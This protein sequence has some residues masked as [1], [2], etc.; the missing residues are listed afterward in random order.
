MSGKGYGGYAKGG[1]G[2]AWSSSSWQN[3]KSS[4]GYEEDAWMG[5]GWQ[6]NDWEGGDWKGR[7]SKGSKKGQKGS[8]EYEDPTNFTD[9]AGRIWQR[10][11]FPKAVLRA[12]V[13]KSGSVFLKDDGLSDLQFLGKDN[14]A[15]VVHQGN[16]HI[17]RRPGI[18]WSEAAASAKCAIS[19][20][21]EH[22]EIPF[23][24]LRNLLVKG[25]PAVKDALEQIDKYS[26][27]CSEKGKTEK[28]ADAMK[29]LQSW[30]KENKKE[31]W[32]A[33]DGVTLGA[34]RAYV[35]GGS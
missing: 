24:T 23:E 20:I 7:Q 21:E 8:G 32:A 18:G 14:L 31:M 10:Y 16:S 30:F 26:R 3:G 6:N 25:G 11:Q 13:D 27:A 15:K 1:K 2:G 34:A 4:K 28:T 9:K 5:K 19:V 29:V 35:C 33:L 17:C 12:S 22:K